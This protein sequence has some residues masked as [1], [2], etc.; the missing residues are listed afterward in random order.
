MEQLQQIIDNLIN[1]HGQE[2]VQEAINKHIGAS[3]DGGTV[4]VCPTGYYWNGS[5][6][7]LNVG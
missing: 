2:A 5:A 6:C 1:E 3:N 4:P 7:V